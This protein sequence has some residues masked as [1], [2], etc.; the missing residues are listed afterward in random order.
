MTSATLA[1]ARAAAEQASVQ[2]LINSYLRESGQALARSGDGF[3]R[4]ALPETGR[5][6][7]LPLLHRGEFS[8]HVYGDELHVETEDG[9]RELIDHAAL[10]RLLL[11]DVAVV[12]ARVFGDQADGEARKRLLTDQIEGS[13]VATARYL[14]HIREEPVTS[15]H[16]LT[17]HA[18]QS[19]VFGHPFHPT[20]KS[21]EGF[22]AALPRY[23]PELG[24]D[25]FLH[26]FAVRPDLLVERRVAE[27]PWVP[28]EVAE[29]ARTRLGHRQDF[30]LIP[31]H[32]WQAGYLRTHPRVAGLV[33]E[34]ALIDL[35]PLGN[36]VYPTSSVRT[37]CDP[38]FATTWKLPLHVRITNFIRNNPVSHLERAADA[39]ALIA[40]LAP[41]W[42]HE[43]FGVLLETGFRTVDPTTVGDDLAADF[44]VLYR[45]NPFTN[46]HAAPRVVASL[47]EERPGGVPVLMR[48]VH[49]AWGRPGAPSAGHVENWLRE[50]LCISLLPLL[51][52]FDADGIS[53][54][55][56][57]QNSLL[58]TDNGWPTRFWVRDMEGTS[59]SRKRLRRA[60]VP[61]CSPLLYDDDEAWTRL[62]YHAV[63]NHLGHLLHVLSRHA[64]VDEARLWR[65]TRELLATGSTEVAWDLL[66]SPV[67][68]AKANLISRFAGRAENPLYTDVPNPLFEV[69]S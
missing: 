52:I 8:H 3:A 12:A 55:A 15:S 25:F 44:S 65:A 39:S 27:G 50:Y 13:I 61:E 20:P 69:R 18:E 1:A 60:V 57:V 38:G 19:L 26:W 67:L 35:G 53:F 49:R 31:V 48:A 33:A 45:Q 21:S 30:T 29:R 6:L 16:A 43:G 40:E 41:T 59:V 56:H 51:E 28:E 34:S 54:E 10:V 42:A 36:R 68:P 62:R 32:P 23:A 24:A 7:V 58:H 66:T 11:D 9:R 63:T 22:G 64:D 4:I 17:R 47:L 2:R 14:G 5:A 46:G 37:V